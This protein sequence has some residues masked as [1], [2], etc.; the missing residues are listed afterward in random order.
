MVSSGEPI[1][2][3]PESASYSQ[4][5]LERDT[6]HFLKL[7]VRSQTAAVLFVFFL[8]F[9]P[10]FLF[11]TPKQCSNVHSIREQCQLTLDNTKPF[12]AVYKKDAE[13]LG[14]MLSSS[15]GV[16]LLNRET[17]D[18]PANTQPTTAI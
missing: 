18:T 3:S 8:F 1:P 4:T 9:F 14:F 12:N 13:Y 17:I 11:V 16:V 10:I 2:F 15:R 7:G 6:A 5:G